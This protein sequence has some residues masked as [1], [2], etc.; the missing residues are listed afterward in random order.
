MAARLY[1]LFSVGC[2]GTSL[3]KDVFRSISVRGVCK[4]QQPLNIYS[5]YLYKV[6]NPMLPV[7]S[8]T[9]HCT[10]TFTDPSCSG[11]RHLPSVPASEEFHEH[12]RRLSEK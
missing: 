6:V 5:S 12:E 7:R 9:L 10:S 8:Q 1:E 2:S 4:L 3:A 11:A